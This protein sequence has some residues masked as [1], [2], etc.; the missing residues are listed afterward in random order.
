MPFQTAVRAVP[1][2][3]VEGDFASQNPRATVL[4]GPGGLI[5]PPEGLIMG[6][7]AWLDRTLLD[8]NNAAI[9][10]HNYGV[11]VPAGFHAREFKGTIITWLAEYSMTV[12]GGTEVTLFTEGDFWV[13][14]YGSNFAVDGHKCYARLSDGAPRF[15]VTG[16]PTTTSLTG[17]IAASTFSAT[18][19][20]DDNLMTVTAVGAGT[21]VPGATISGTNVATGSKV[22][23]QI[24]PLISGETLGGIGRYSVSISDQSVASTAI[25]G[26]YGTLTV[27]AGSGVIVGGVLSGTN[28][29]AG[30]QVTAFGTGTG[31]SGTYI[32]DATGTA[33]STAIT[34]T[35]DVETPWVCRSEGAANEIVKITRWI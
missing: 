28:V 29:P 16:S 11:G 2:A 27:T 20:I 19:R 22:L 30:S 12:M 32:T 17:S 13:K 15:G 1:A 9:L 21:I 31:G 3:A 33:A 7:F 10:T 4:A 5:A 18:G 35:L 25:S 23:G 26:T 24:L 14:N 6:R 34:Q 8:V